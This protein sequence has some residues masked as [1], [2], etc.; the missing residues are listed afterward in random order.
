MAKRSAEINTPVALANLTRLRRVCHATSP[1]TFFLYVPTEY[2]ESPNTV[3][4]EGSQIFI[5]SPGKSGN[6][7]S[8]VPRLHFSDYRVNQAVNP[9]VGGKLGCEWLPGIGICSL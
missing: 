6:R 8:S 1:A 7:T 4:P 9:F 3:R 2:V 5:P